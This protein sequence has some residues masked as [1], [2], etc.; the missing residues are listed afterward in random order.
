MFKAEVI[1]DSI[2][3]FSSKR[4]TTFVVTF[5]RFILPEFNTHRATSKNGASSR[6][7]SLKTAIKK[8]KDN[9]FIPFYWG[10]AQSGMQAD[11]ELSVEKIEEAKKL[12]LEAMNSAIYYAEKLGDLGLHKQLASR[13]LE[14]FSY[15]TMIVS[16]TE[17]DNFF[18][19]RADRDAQ[20]EFQKLAYMMLEAYNQSKPVIK[21]VGEWHI[22]FED[23]MP[24]G[25][26]DVEKIKIACA[27]CA[28]V[29]YNNHDGEIGLDKGLSIYD[30]LLN[31]RLI[32]A[33]PS[34]HIARVNGDLNPSGNLTG[35]WK[36]YRKM[37]EK[38]TVN[39]DVRVTK[40]RIMNGEL[41]SQVG[42]LYPASPFV[43]S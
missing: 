9:P 26:S 12:W 36:Q 40:W 19:L 24:E 5:P 8:V 6:A 35:G 14:V 39:N 43:K 23:K 34:E 10:A 31:S 32:H 1:K 20:P 17:W 38:E 4:M 2:S 22:P 28:A 30:R 15:Q 11:Q 27:R 33:S 7:I 37:L 3:A 29:S 18:A 21:C 42:S 41:W 25:I 16:G 13:L